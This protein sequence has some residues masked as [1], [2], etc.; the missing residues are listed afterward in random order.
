MAFNKLNVITKIKDAVIAWQV[1]PSLQPTYGSPS[2]VKPD[3]T[4][5]AR[6]GVAGTPDTIVIV[7]QDPIGSF[8]ISVTGTKKTLI[9]SNTGGCTIVYN[10]TYMVLP[11][12]LNSSMRDLFAVN[13]STAEVVCTDGETGKWKMTS[14]VDT[15]YKT[16]FPA[17]RATVSAGSQ[18]FLN[19]GL[20]YVTGTTTINAI[21]MGYIGSIAMVEFGSVCT[22]TYNATTLILPSKASITTAVGDTAVF[23]RDAQGATNV[24]RCI[25]YQ[26]ASGSA[27]VS[28]TVDAYTK[29]ETDTAIQTAV[30]SIDS[31]L[32]AI[33][34]EVI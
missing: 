20:N 24:A 27:L 21:G 8:G 29:A 11:T 19:D 16:A 7:G 28:S 14:Y 31:V 15:V 12:M 32:N 17:Y 4:G 34:G 3:I 13:G 22:L 2:S 18:I 33:N 10:A 1:M 26:R 6:I 23:V 25:S 5:T 9:F 30:G